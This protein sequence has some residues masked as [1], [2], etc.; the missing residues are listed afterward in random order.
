[1]TQLDSL[2]ANKV[3]LD[4]ILISNF[5]KSYDFTI[6]YVDNNGVI[7]KL[8]R[9]YSYLSLTTDLHEI[10]AEKINGKWICTGKLLLGGTGTILE[11]SDGPNLN[12][13]SI[14]IP[15]FA[16]ITNNMG[17]NSNIPLALSI[18]GYSS[19]SIV[20]DSTSYSGVLS[21][22]YTGTFYVT[23]INDTSVAYM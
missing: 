11:L 1:M 3:L 5:A 6:R 18:I 15:K 19:A 14:F 12:K 20:V 8:T 13:L 17:T 21:I 10:I 16:V 4:K 22:S 7:Q 2:N 23:T 9:T